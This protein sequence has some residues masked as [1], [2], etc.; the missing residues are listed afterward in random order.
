MEYRCYFLGPDGRIFAR[1]EFEAESDDTALERAWTMFATDDK[2]PHPGF[3]LWESGRR[4]Y[5]HN[6]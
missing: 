6:C 5:T 4:I 2:A 1:R 3:E